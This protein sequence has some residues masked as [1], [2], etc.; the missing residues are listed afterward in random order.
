MN[1]ANRPTWY[2]IG[3][4][5]G[6]A[7]LS[8]NC[9]NPDS[10]IG[11]YQIEVATTNRTD[12]VYITDTTTGV[13]KWVK[14][15][16][17]PDQ[18]GIPFEKMEKDIRAYEEKLGIKK[19]GE[20]DDIDKETKERMEQIIDAELAAIVEAATERYHKK[21]ADGESGEKAEEEYRQ[22]M[23]T[24]KL[25]HEIARDAIEEVFEKDG[26]PEDRPVD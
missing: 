18:L 5:F 22:A 25:A 7:L 21:L 2:A 19:I 9:V 10:Q 12:S 6:I 8:V 15:W 24:A 16:Y 11:R 23:E 1:H 14:A 4:L 13:V 20:G 17:G 3:V 26:T